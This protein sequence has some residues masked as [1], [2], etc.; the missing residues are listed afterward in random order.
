MRRITHFWSEGP[1]HCA[2]RLLLSYSLGEGV[3]A[4][5]N[6]TWHASETVATEEDEAGGMRIGSM[7]TR[8]HRCRP[9]HCPRLRQ[10]SWLSAAGYALAHDQNWQ[11]QHI[12]ARRPASVPELLRG[13]INELAHDKAYLS[14]VVTV[15]VTCSL[16]QE[17]ASSPRRN[18]E[19]SGT[20]RGLLMVVWPGR[21]REAGCRNPAPPG[22]SRV[23]RRNVRKQ[24]PGSASTS[25]F[26]HEWAADSLVATPRAGPHLLPLP[27][28]A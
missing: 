4:T 27:D 18:R 23:W 5:K 28:R 26:V 20:R 16:T 25:S 24:R 19:R 10:V 9:P 1:T 13:K 6:W 15:E 8:L 21:V 2:T 7:Q 22:R 3:P 17:E 14:Q 11:G 12:A